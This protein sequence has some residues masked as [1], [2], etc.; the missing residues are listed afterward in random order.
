LGLGRLLFLEAL[1]QLVDSHAIGGALEGL[2]LFFVAFNRVLRGA[3]E[4][5][6]NGGL[7]VLVIF[8]KVAVKQAQGGVS[9]LS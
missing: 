5:L 8:V 9:P 1:V 4:H 6:I 3:V 7:V 2:M